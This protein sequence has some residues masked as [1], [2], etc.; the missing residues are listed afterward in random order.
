MSTETILISYITDDIAIGRAKA[1]QPDDDLFSIGILD[2]LGALQM[3]MFIEEKF[4]ITV[5]D[6]DVIFENFNSISAMTNYIDLRKN[7]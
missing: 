4:S 6:E 5:P 3:V 7:A 1:I 2:S